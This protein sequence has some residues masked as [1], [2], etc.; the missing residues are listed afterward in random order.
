MEKEFSLNDFAEE[1]IEKGRKKFGRAPTYGE[2]EEIIAEEK[3][4]KGTKII[5][6]EKV[7]DNYVEKAVLGKEFNLSEKRKEIFEL[8]LKYLPTKAGRIYRIIKQQDEEFIKRLKGKLG[9][10]AIGSKY[11]EEVIDKLA[12]QVRS[13]HK[14]D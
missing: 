7:D 10:K 2:V 11:A 6:V 3:K 9:V 8:L 4:F 1:Y 13:S 14:V 5:G 12:G